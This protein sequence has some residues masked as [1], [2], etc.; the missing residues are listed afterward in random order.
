MKLFTIIAG[1]KEEVVSKRGARLFEM[2]KKEHPVLKDHAKVEEMLAML[3]RDDPNDYPAKEAIIRVILTQ[4]R[5]GH[6][7]FWSSLLIVVFGRMLCRLRGRVQP[8]DFDSDELDQ[9]VLVSFLTAIKR[10][11][12]GNDHRLCMYIRQMTGR[13]FFNWLLEECQRRELVAFI[14][15]VALSQNAPSAWPVP[16]MIK[17]TR[18]RR[19][20]HDAGEVEEM[21]DLLKAR[22]GNA[23]DPKKLELV[24]ATAIQGE[25]LRNYVRRLHGNSD[26]AALERTYQ[27]VK[28]QRNRTIAQLREVF[29]NKA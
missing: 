27:R 13:R 18:A 7:S 24:I 11:H 17:R 29:F 9:M 21:I 4:H 1:L 20:K 2:A 10:V 23:V 3:D 15:P 25:K 5:E 8:D 6:D 16:G 22:V 14:E 19:L 26:Q 28:K 12:L